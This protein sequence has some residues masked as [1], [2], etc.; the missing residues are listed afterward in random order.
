MHVLWGI[1][2]VAAG[3]FLLVCGTL[4]SEFI[5]YRLLVARS[6]MLW[7]E[8]THRFHQVAGAIIIVLGVLWAL[9]YIW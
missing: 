2:M 7:G 1:L 9:G 8:Y 6:K 5:I 4:R 3:L